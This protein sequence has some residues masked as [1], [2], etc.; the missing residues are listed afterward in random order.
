MKAGNF[1]ITN[2]VRFGGK[3]LILGFNPNENAKLPYS[4]PENYRD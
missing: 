4:N 1:D 3:T 2:E